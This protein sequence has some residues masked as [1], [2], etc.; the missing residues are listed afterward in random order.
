VV[1][2]VV[3]VVAVV[4]VVV[5]VFAIAAADCSH[6]FSWPLTEYLNHLLFGLYPSLHFEIGNATSWIQN[7]P[8][9][10]METVL[11]QQ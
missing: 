4:V 3:V 1:V 11:C 8:I 10:R 7:W 6:S 2:V 5:V 9:K